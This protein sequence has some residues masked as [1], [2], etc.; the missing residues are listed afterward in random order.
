MITAFKIRPSVIKQ[1]DLTDEDLAPYLRVKLS[2]HDTDTTFREQIEQA[3]EG[4]QVKFCGIERVRQQNNQQDDEQTLFE[5][6][7][8]IEALNPHSLL[9]Q[10]F[11][12]NKDMAGQAVPKELEGLLSQVID[13][14]NAEDLL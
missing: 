9:E 7:S 2:A 1:L 8:Q 3:L 13:E 4:K 5:D 11:A 12:N 10:A 14:L 6:V